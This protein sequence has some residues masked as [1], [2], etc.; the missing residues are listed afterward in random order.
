MSPQE[1]ITAKIHTGFGHLDRDGDGALT[2]ADHHLMGRSVARGL[3]YPE[4]S[5]E[6]RA[7]IDAYL[8]IWHEVHVPMD[9]DGDGRISREEF[10][11]STSALAGDAERADAALGGLAD[12]IVDI[13][14]R[15]G[16]DRIRVD[17][18][19]A[20]I[21]GQAPGL[22]ETEVHEAFR[23]LDLDGDGTLTRAELRRAVIDYFT[24]ADLDAPGNW[25]FGTP[26][27]R[28]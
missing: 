16:D 9:T 18:Y 22:S 10:V 2:E 27:H 24:S 3:G 26:A 19:T 8:R 13:A 1:F 25:Y 21:R 28:M 14:D 7:V 23:H 5:P 4:D 17:E 6:E 20:F 12:R 11:A 15:D